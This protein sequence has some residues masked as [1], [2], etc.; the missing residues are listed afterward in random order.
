MEMVS[1]CFGLLFHLYYL[2][3]NNCDPT[4]MIVPN[5]GGFAGV[6]LLGVATDEYRSIALICVFVHYQWVACP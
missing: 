5:S 2:K 1:D 3:G 4:R 6:D